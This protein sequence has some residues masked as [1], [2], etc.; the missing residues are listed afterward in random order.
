MTEE[1]II[2]QL[3][4]VLATVKPGSD[5]SAINRDSRLREDIGLDSLSM[6]LMGLAIETSFSIRCPDT[7]T[8]ETVGEVVDFIREATNPAFHKVAF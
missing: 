8:F 3:K 2:E 5:F 4:S 6:L 7:I 1:E